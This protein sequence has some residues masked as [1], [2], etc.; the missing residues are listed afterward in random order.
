MFD[1]I[2][3]NRLQINM[4]RVSLHTFCAASPVPDARVAFHSDDKKY[5]RQCVKTSDQQD[6]VCLCID[7]LGKHIDLCTAICCFS[8][9]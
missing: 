7:P 6:F 1:E 8:R 3:S 2:V 4:L 9:F 5:N